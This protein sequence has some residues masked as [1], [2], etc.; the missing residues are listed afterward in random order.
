MYRSQQ[1]RDTSHVFAPY[2]P[3]YP[4]QGLGVYRGMGD[5]CSQYQ[6]QVD[7][8]QGVLSASEVTYAALKAV[9]DANPDDMAAQ[10]SALSA[11]QSLDSAQMQLATAQAQLNACQT[12]YVEPSPTNPVVTPSATPEVLPD[13]V[14][15][16]VAPTPAVVPAV[17][18]APSVVPV[19]AAGSTNWLL[20]LG[21]VTLLGV[22]AMFVLRKK[23]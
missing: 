12:P 17:V 9:A 5:D 1:Y 6:A 2:L 16:P 14:V 22:G 8:F 15:T 13:P 3:P 23:R 20:V 10:G 7:A 21:G 19:K 11:K 4:M 18:P